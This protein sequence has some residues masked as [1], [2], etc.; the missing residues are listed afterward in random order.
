MPT[1]GRHRLITSSP[2]TSANVVTISK[3]SSAL[4]PIRPAWR[5]SFMLAMP[6]TTVQNTIGAIVIRMILIKASPSGFRV[7][8]SAG[9]KMPASTPRTMAMRTWR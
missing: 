2:T 4:T 6:C 9:H 5:M 1:P 7:S 8:L 3:Y